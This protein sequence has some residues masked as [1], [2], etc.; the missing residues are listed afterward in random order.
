MVCLCAHLHHLLQ[1]QRVDVQDVHVAVLDVQEAQVQGTEPA[2][3][4][5]TDQM[6]GFNEVRPK[7]SI[8]ISEAFSNKKHTWPRVSVA[9]V[10]SNL[11]S[12]Q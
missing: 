7:A 10:H 2:R 6:P 5:H 11:L 9:S 8:K 4:K 3:Y 1:L 12:L